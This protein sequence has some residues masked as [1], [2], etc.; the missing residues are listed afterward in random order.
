M[1]VFPRF[2][3]FLVF[4]LLLLNV[5]QMDGVQPS[6]FNVTT[7]TTKEIFSRVWDDISLNYPD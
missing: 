1:K 4:M 5:V 3:L 7:A 6:Q 2:I